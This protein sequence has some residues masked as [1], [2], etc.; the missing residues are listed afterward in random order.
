[1]NLTDSARQIA[2]G[3]YSLSQNMGGH[4]HA[5]LLDDG[6]GLTILDTL[7]D[8]DAH[9]VLEALKALNRPVTDLKN[10]VLTHA[11]RSHLGGMAVLK[12]QS[13]ATVWAHTWEADIIAGER[14]A[15]RVSP[16]PRLPLR[17]YPL[18]LGLALGFGKHPPCPVDRPLRDGD[19]VG[20]V[21]VLHVPG[22]TPGSLAFYWPDRKALFAGDIIATWPRFEPGW[23]GFTLNFKQSRASLGKLAELGAAEILAVGHGEPVVGTGAERVRAAYQMAAKW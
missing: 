14:E 16:L 23:K 17:V 10:I 18:Q 6:T 5:F 4:V 7:Y 15:Q 20:P 21:D 3:V 19:R 22:H 1:M 13:G 11:H 2:P 8:T 9:R 12:Q